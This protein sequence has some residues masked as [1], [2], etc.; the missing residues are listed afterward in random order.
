MST[1]IEPMKN[2]RKVSRKIMSK[3]DKKE[4]K[5]LRKLRQQGRG[6]SGFDESSSGV[7]I[8]Y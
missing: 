7:M 4:H 1:Y 2:T 3:Q 6:A 5:Q 8:A